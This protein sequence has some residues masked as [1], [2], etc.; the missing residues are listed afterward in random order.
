VNKEIETKIIYENEYVMAFLDINP[1]GELS[2]HTLVITKKHYQNIHDVDE[3]DL[4]ELIK[5]VKRIAIAVKNVSGADGVNI[6]QNNEKAAGQLVP[7]IHFHVI[8]RKNGDGIWFDTKRR[9]LRP[10]EQAQVSDL[11]REEL[12]KQTGFL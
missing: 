7:H 4:E 11:I 2:G 1:A 10:L 12:K 8:P 9:A 3:K 5:T 6:L